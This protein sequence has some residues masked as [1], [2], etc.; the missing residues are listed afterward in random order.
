[1]PKIKQKIQLMIQRTS[2]I[3]MLLHRK[4]PGS[5]SYVYAWDRP[6]ARREIELSGARSFFTTIEFQTHM[7]F[8]RD[9]GNAAAPYGAVRAVRPGIVNIYN[10]RIVPQ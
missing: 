5:E 8:E 10:A 4:R 6:P 3:I 1:M 2:I 9:F 7:A